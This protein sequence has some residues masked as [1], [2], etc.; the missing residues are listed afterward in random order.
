VA[1]DHGLPFAP[2]LDIDLRA[3]RHL[4]IGRFA[5]VPTPFAANPRRV[6]PAQ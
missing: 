5:H 3:V 1:E 4:H 2:I 6:E